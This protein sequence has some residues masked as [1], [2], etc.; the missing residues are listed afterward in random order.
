VASSVED[1]V[2]DN[3]A[4][5]KGGLLARAKRKLVDSKERWAR[6]GR[7]LTG[8]AAQRE[9]ERLPPGQR[10]VENWPVLDLGIQPDVPA[11]H[12]RLTIDGLVENPVTWDW[13]AFRAQPVFRDVSDIHCVTAWS[14]FDNAWEGVGARHI[15]DTV[16]PKSGAQFIILHSYDDYT[17]NLPLAEFASDDVLLAH[18]WQ[19]KPLTAAHGGPVRAI[20]PKLYFWKSAKWLKRIE[21]AAQDSAGFWEQRG[22]HA[23]GDPWTEE[24][25][26]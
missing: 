9:S 4:N 18:S 16:K 15:L 25:Y 24:R 21:F 17:T 26:G 6:D 5:E 10:Q 3:G 2:A 14:R 11:E 1:R 20:V 7:L 23:H 12:W 13:A 19:G 8:R 22:Y